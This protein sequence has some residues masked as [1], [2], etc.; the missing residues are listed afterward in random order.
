[1]GPCAVEMI[2]CD[3][4]KKALTPLP[5]QFMKPAD[6]TLGRSIKIND[7]YITRQEVNDW[8][9]SRHVT[10]HETLNR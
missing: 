7:F 6:R 8:S 10:K 3:D 9:R 5:P 2:D 4:L 1:M